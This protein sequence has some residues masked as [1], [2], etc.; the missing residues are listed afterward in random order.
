M[1]SPPHFA[2]A[3]PSIGNHGYLHGDG[4]PLPGD[5]APLHGDGAPPGPSRPASGQSDNNDNPE[6][7]VGFR[8]RVVN[9][10]FQCRED[11]GEIGILNGNFGPERN[12]RRIRDYTR[13]NLKKSPATIIALQ[14]ASKAVGDILYSE[15]PIAPRAAGAPAVIAPAVAGQAGCA[16]TMASRPEAKFLVAMGDENGATLLTAVRHSLA[17]GIKTLQWY[18]HFDGTY[19]EHGQ[20]KTAR[21]RVLISEIRWRKRTALMDKFV[22]ANV[23]F[24]YKT[25]KKHTGLAAAHGTFFQE[26]YEMLVRFGVNCM[27]GDFNM[28]V[29]L[30]VSIL[31]Q[32]GLI[33]DLA[34]IYPWRKE[35]QES[36][37]SDSSA[38]FLIGGCQKI[39]LKFSLAS[40]T[41]A[42]VNAATVVA[43][44]AAAQAQGDNH[45][46]GFDHTLDV[47][48]KGQGYALTSYLP[49]DRTAFAKV[50]EEMFTK[51]TDIMPGLNDSPDLLPKWKQKLV[52][53]NLFDPDD[54]LF[55]SGAHM[56]LLGFLG[57]ISTRSD[58]RL[59]G[60]EIRNR[61]KLQEKRRQAKAKGDAENED[62]KDNNQ[63]AA[64]SS[65]PSGAS[66]SGAFS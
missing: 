11:V 49:E 32:F 63:G 19:R 20:R 18:W 21:S 47:F 14:E 54:R 6:S 42:A 58:G 53:F 51:S 38:I 29:F 66:P 52:Q 4:A 59:L 48:R 15:E 64:S 65:S 27:S 22:H 39:T 33:I 25:A 34:A 7:T 23:H 56:P 8:G 1:A 28:S 30:V 10:P 57:N 16:A 40:F 50:I 62:D 12:D 61:E 31:R 17:T 5:G 60:R 37:V 24:H 41:P 13:E 2:P 44:A 45:G 35:G 46:G 43:P 55:R 26:L 9:K 36:S 3:D